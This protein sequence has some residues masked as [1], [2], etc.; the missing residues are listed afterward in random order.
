MRYWDS[1]ALLP[2]L[3]EE[4]ETE[5][6]RRQLQADPQIITWWGSRIECVSALNRLHREAD[7]DTK[8]LERILEDLQTLS[9]G[10]LEIQPTERLRQRALRLL[11]LHPLH[12][13]DAL[14]LA[15]ALIACGESPHTLPVLCGDTQ[16]TEAARTEGFP[17]LV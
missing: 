5:L 16:L 12:A 4:E 1:S 14:Q 2:L 7:L 6:R 11:R 10:W 3:A 15:A 13:A 8:S 9:T 17:V